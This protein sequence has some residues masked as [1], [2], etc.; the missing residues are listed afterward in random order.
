MPKVTCEGCD[1]FEGVGL[2]TAGPKYPEYSDI[3][4]C[5]NRQLRKDML[6]KRGAVLWAQ[7]SDGRGQPMRRL[8]KTLR[9]CNYRRSS[10]EKEVQ[11]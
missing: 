11:S 3:G 8:S 1:Y 6:A 4:F 9:Y 5:Q 2:R 10:D 7:G